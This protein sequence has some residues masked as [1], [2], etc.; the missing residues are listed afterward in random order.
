V[1]QIHQCFGQ[2]FISKVVNR[3]LKVIHKTKVED[4]LYELEADY[5]KRPL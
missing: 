5:T 3:R 2:Q 1:G 4:S